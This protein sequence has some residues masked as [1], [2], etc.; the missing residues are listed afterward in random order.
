MTE[1]IKLKQ[2]LAHSMNYLSR[3]PS[4]QTGYLPYFGGK[5]SEN[6]PP[7]LE[8]CY[9]DYGDG[10][11][12]FLE[13]C[14]LAKKALGYSIP[15]EVEQGLWDQLLRFLAEDG[16]FYSPQTPW[17]RGDYADIWYQ[18]GVLLALSM[19]YHELKQASDLEVL[20][21]M[22]EGLDRV[23]IRQ[24]GETWFYYAWDKQNRSI[25]EMSTNPCFILI[26]VLTFCAQATGNDKSLKIAKELIHSMLHGKHRYF[27]EDGSVY[28]DASQEELKAFK[29]NKLEF[30]IVDGRSVFETKAA[31][32]IN[33]GHVVSRT[34][35]LLG[36]IRYSLFTN[37]KKLLDFAK[38]TYNKFLE[39]YCT[40]FGWV[41]ENLLTSGTECSE[42]CGTADMVAS[43]ILLAKAGYTEYW[44]HCE[45]FIRNH[46][47]QAQFFPND[48]TRDIEIKH[49]KLIPVLPDDRASYQDVLER[50]SGGFAGPIYPDDLFCYYPQSRFNSEASRT[51]D[52]SGCCSPS[53]I[54]AVALA[55]LN[56][57]E[58]VDDTVYVNL[59]MDWENDDVRVSSSLPNAGKVHVCP[60]RKMDVC[61][62]LPGWCKTADDVTASIDGLALKAIINNGYMQ[63]GRIPSGKEAV[64]EI[65]L[66]ESMEK[67]T[68]GQIPYEISWKGYE[69]VSLKNQT[70]YK[71]LYGCYRDRDRQVRDERN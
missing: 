60:K 25:D 50:L 69:I 43:Q 40:S 1:M 5:V 52:I 41:P 39:T 6:T 30:K 37:D 65:A 63:C 44:D 16:L 11:G 67:M 3:N 70:D 45:R 14:Q 51:I 24:R 29:D 57:V 12:R 31:W 13:A 64:L 28:F 48:M 27:N 2:I 68:V 61:I 55:T 54:K 10:T 34:T 56:A 58:V 20:N 47:R 23:A 71:A 36:L 59:L 4:P 8:R 38:Q 18:R 53:G 66:P 46:V 35:G 17:S 9:W 49:R 32:L 26:D 62:R 21:R 19:R 33:S 42:M 15:E 22:V 7:K